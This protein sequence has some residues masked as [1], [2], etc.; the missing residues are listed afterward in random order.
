MIN[1]ETLKFVGLL[2]ELA[3]RTLEG[4][5][6]FEKAVNPSN[7][8]YYNS[9]LFDDYGYAVVCDSCTIGGHNDII[10]YYEKLNCYHIRAVLDV[11]GEPVNPYLEVIFDEGD[12]VIV[13]ENGKWHFS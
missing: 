7:K 10:S 4:I 1:I 2:N 8:I 12:E 6:P 5:E 11:E 3:E 9:N 13:I